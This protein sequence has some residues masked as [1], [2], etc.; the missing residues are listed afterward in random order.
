MPLALGA[1]RRF[2]WTAPRYG[3]DGREGGSDEHTI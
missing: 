3:T 1:A 2:R